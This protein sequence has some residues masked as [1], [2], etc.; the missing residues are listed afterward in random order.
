MIAATWSNMAFRRAPVSCV[1]DY[2]GVGDRGVVVGGRIDDGDII[3][4][5]LAIDMVV[6]GL[7]WVPLRE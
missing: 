4:H 5:G 6:F 1:G 2:V 3:E 7:C